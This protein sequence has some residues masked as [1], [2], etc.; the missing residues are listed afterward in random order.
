[1]RNVLVAQLSTFDDVQT[2]TAHNGKEGLAKVQTEMP[3]VI[4]SDLNMPVMDGYTLW[5]KL[6]ELPQTQTLLFVLITSDNRS[7]ES[8]QKLDNITHDPGAFVLAKNNV[9]RRTLAEIIERVR[10]KP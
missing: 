6:R 3:N 8:K 4:F 2:T 10:P 1:M 7:P 5:Q 9:T